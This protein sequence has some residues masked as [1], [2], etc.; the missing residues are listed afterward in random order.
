MIPLLQIALSNVAVAAVLALVALVAGRLSRRPALRHSLW[1]LVLIKLVTPPLVLL[2]LPWPAPAAEPTTI[3]SV[4]PVETVSKPAPAMPDPQLPAPESLPAV[5]EE[6]PPGQAP[7]PGTMA[8]FE[9]LVVAPEKPVATDSDPTPNSGEKEKP[10]AAPV[11]AT[12]PPAEPSRTLERGSSSAD[13]VALW[14]C[15]IGCLWP[16]GTIAWFTVAGRRLWRFAHS[17]RHARPAPPALQAEAEALAQRLGLTDW[18]RVWLVPGA[19]SPMLWAVGRTPRLLLPM[20]LL[21]RLD[22]ERRATLL[23]HELAHWRRRDHWVRWLELVVL[24]LYWWCP[25]V[26]WAH[27][28]LSDAEEECCDAWV[29]WALPGSGRAYAAT[30]VDTLDFLTD[31]PR[32]VPLVARAVGQISV[33]RRRLT[34]IMRGTTPRTLSSFGLA[35]VFGLGLLLLPL[36]PTWGPLGRES[37]AA[38]QAPKQ[39]PQTD[40]PKIQDEIEKLKKQL[41]ELSAKAAK[42]RAAEEQQKQKEVEKLLHQ[43]KDLQAKFSTVH[44]DYL[45]QMKELHD[46]IH[47]LGWA[48]PALPAAP[49]SYYVPLTTYQAVPMAGPKVGYAVSQPPYHMTPVPS[50]VQADLEKRV[51]ELE[52]KVDMLMK[53]LHKNPP[54]G[55]GA[56]KYPDPAKPGAPGTGQPETLQNPE[57]AGELPSSPQP[58]ESQQY[59]PPG[60]VPGSAPK[61]PKAPGSNP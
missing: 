51:R 59:G 28:E 21:E 24:G 12:V 55:T 32:A 35:A 44:K 60:G 14:F 15:L 40:D 37:T 57:P 11:L 33:L 46:R 42:D 17:L 25:L 6:L 31:A 22:A 52:K 56:P 3:D 23:V 36:L 10:D 45:A 30:L 43:I 27:R 48:P 19:V 50:P 61:L 4:Q 47:K 1:L 18:P 58:I 9:A 8:E 34:M 5:V 53:Q 2:P 41:E 54:G 16:A 49:G 29:V 13:V 7:A 26:W 38:A 39:P 20:G